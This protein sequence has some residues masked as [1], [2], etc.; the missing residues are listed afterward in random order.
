MTT[1]TFE[2]VLTTDNFTDADA[3]R[4]FEHGGGDATPVT[5]QDITRL[6]FD[7]E[8]ESLEAA[9]ASATADTR[10]ADLAIARIELAAPAQ[11][12]G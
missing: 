9:I 3:D 11:H 4:L 2:I 12:A 10:A 6:V 8:A 5:R 1:Y 7:R